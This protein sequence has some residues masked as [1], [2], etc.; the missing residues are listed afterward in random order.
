[1]VTQQTNWLLG[2]D[3]IRTKKKKK[4]EDEGTE[5]WGDTNKHTHIHNINT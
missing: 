2:D 3:I 4:A 1:M 5:Q